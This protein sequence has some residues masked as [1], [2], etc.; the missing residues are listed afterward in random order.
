[1][2]QYL[3]SYAI[4][5]DEILSKYCEMIKIIE[6]HVR[7]ESFENECSLNIVQ[8]KSFFSSCYKQHGISRAHKKWLYSLLKFQSFS[9]SGNLNNRHFLSKEQLMRIIHIENYYYLRIVL[10]RKVAPFHSRHSD[11]CKTFF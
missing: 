5:Y 3:D 2:Q 11:S 7:T 4:D 6:T 10:L 1:M 9:L 8:R